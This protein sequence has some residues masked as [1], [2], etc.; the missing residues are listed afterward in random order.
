MNFENVFDSNSITNTELKEKFGRQLDSGAVVIFFAKP[1]SNPEFINV[2][3]A[4]KG[5]NL[6]RAS[7]V[8]RVSAAA[9]MLKGWDGQQDMII[10]RTQDNYS[11]EVL[12]DLG[13]NKAGATLAGMQL[14]V[15]DTSEPAYPTQTPII[16]SRDGSQRT[17]NGQPIYSQTELVTDEEFEVL[18]GH[19]LMKYDAVAAPAFNIPQHEDSLSPGAIGA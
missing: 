18:G 1:S 2:Y 14:R 11:A 6:S 15:F 10:L 13:I 4:Q 8:N 17:S 7:A 9:S 12:E 3:L 19:S 16:S 5:T